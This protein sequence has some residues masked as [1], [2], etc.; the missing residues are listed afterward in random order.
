MKLFSNLPERLTD[1]DFEEKQTIICS[2]FPKKL[3]FDG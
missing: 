3:Q 2:I 1:W